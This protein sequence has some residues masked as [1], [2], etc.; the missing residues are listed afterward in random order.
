MR[1]G[2]GLAMLAGLA[3]GQTA[4]NTATEIASIR[5]QVRTY[6][7]ELPQ[8]TCTEST[9]QTI[10]IALA[11]LTETRED[12]CD[13]HQYKLFAVQSMAG[14]GGRASEQPAR[15]NRGPVALDWRARLKEASLGATTGFLAALLDPQADAGFRWVR[16][17]K[18]NGRAVSV[19]AFYAAMPEGYL[20]ADSNGSVRVPFKGLLYADAATNALVRVEIRCVHIPRA[21]D[22][23]GADVAVDFGSF[24]VN[25]RMVELPSHSIVRFQMKT[26]DAANEADYRGYRLASFGVDSQIRFVDESADEKKE[27]KR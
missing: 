20:L 9:R 3:W 6:L 12:S 18:L 8:I 24:V 23:D 21:S 19:Y 17:G 15:R 4:P 22:Y 7:D 13:I 25:G 1:A 5:D 26:G 14:L 27:D 11:E 16:M 2:F 10:R